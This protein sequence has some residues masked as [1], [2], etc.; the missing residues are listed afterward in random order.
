[1]PRASQRAPHIT[2]SG[3]SSHGGHR[4]SDR[5]LPQRRECTEQ[6]ALE[7]FF[8]IVIIRSYRVRVGELDYDAVT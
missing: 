4:R 2:H 8:Y 7:R 6:S 3:E 1:M 5:P